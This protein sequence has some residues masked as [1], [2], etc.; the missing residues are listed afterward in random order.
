M[1][2]KQPRLLRYAPEFL[3][4]K[5]GLDDEEDLFG[6]IAVDDDASRVVEALRDGYFGTGFEFH[7]KRLK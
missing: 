3:D 7:N 6:S 5:L 2:T 1:D 4:V